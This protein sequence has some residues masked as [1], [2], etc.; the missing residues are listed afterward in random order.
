MVD[1]EANFY[2]INMHIVTVILS[3]RC[4]IEMSSRDQMLNAILDSKL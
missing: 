2:R 4:H 3:T 1:V